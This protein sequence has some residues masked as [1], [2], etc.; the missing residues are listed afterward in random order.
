MNCKLFAVNVI[1]AIALRFPDESKT[2]I[3]AICFLYPVKI[4]SVA[5]EQEGYD[6]MDKLGEH[7]Q[8]YLGEGNLIGN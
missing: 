8:K 3:G 1:E 5:T 6:A 4:I 2:V 7:Y